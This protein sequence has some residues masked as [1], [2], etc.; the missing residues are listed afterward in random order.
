MLGGFESESREVL[1]GVTLDA[2]T[3]SSTGFSVTILADRATSFPVLDRCP[4]CHPLIARNRATGLPVLDGLY[5]D[6]VW[7][8]GL[9]VESSVESCGNDF[10]DV[11]VVELEELVDNPGTTIGTQCF[12]V[13]L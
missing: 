2:D 8:L 1:A 11:L 10:R 12:R 6:V 7:S 5:F 9:D 3:P 13:T 4:H